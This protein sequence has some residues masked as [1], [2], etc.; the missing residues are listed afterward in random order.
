M[1]AS[2]FCPVDGCN[3][4]PTRI[5][6][7][8]FLPG[9]RVEAMEDVGSERTDST[10]GLNIGLPGEKVSLGRDATGKERFDYRPRVA[11]ETN[12]VKS[13]EIAKANNLTPHE[14]ARYRTVGQR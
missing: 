10:R 7:R 8:D 11:S 5:F 3:D 4:V 6:T 12:G 2:D 13:R 14:R 1:L 9:V